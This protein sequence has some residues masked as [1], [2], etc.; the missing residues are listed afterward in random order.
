MHASTAT[1][2]SV[3]KNVLLLSEFISTH[4]QAGISTFNTMHSAL[5]RLHLVL[6]L[7]HVN[8]DDTLTEYFNPYKFFVNEI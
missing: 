6:I 2:V 7:V 8:P 4:G 3:F 5:P 1:F